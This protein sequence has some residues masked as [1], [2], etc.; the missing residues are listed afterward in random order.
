LSELQPAAEVGSLVSSTPR[1]HRGR[2]ACPGVLSDRGL[3]DF[4]A[5][6][7]PFSVNWPVVDGLPATDQSP[8]L[9]M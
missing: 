1:P 9:K 5:R 8:T 3:L 2:R 4:L 6:T 7:C